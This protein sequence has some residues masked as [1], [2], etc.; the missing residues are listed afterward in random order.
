MSL[1]HL[2]SFDSSLSF[3]PRSRCPDRL[4]QRDGGTTRQRAGQF[5]RANASLRRQVSLQASG[6]GDWDGLTGTAGCPWRNHLLATT[7]HVLYCQSLLCGRIHTQ[8]QRTQNLDTRASAPNASRVCTFPPQGAWPWLLQTGLR[9]DL[10][11]ALTILH[12]SVEYAEYNGVVQSHW[13]APSAAR[14]LAAA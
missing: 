4:A 13:T 12:I 2:H 1:I 10:G 7:L 6:N 5:P 8:S 9:P 3:L 14:P 11:R